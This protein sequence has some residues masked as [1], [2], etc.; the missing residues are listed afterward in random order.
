MANADSTAKVLPAEREAV[1]RTVD[2]LPESS[3]AK[4]VRPVRRGSGIFV[5]VASSLDPYA[6]LDRLDRAELDETDEA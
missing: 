4:P 5:S 3:R 1:L 6:G 2:R